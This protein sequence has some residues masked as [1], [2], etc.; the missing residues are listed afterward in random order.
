M[1]QM[2]LDEIELRKKSF[3]DTIK[4]ENWQKVMSS[5]IA[6]SL[7]IA[8]FVFVLIEQNIFETNL[9]SLD[10]SLPLLL[11]RYRYSILSYS[12]LRER[13][14][15]NNSLS[16]FEKDKIYGFDL[17][18]LYNDHSIE[19]EGLI[20]MLEARHSD[21]LDPIMKVM[22]KIDSKDFCSQIIKGDETKAN[23]TTL[24][25]EDR[26][27]NNCWNFE[28]GIFQKGFQQALAN[29]HKRFFDL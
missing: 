29:F 11:N 21:V 2:S 28:E 16:S 7:F 25:K 27:H 18:N 22:L 14:L 4:T 9:K 26:I 24:S 6:G 17:D 15:A 10:R 8:Y 3:K 19:V 20:N 5:L 1:E 12:F 13:I 23:I